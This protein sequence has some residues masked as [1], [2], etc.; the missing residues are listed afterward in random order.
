[1]SF[2]VSLS[3]FCALL[4]GTKH[5]H[6]HACRSRNLHLK[7]RIAEWGNFSEH[8]LGAVWMSRRAFITHKHLK[9]TFCILKLLLR[10][11]KG[12]FIGGGSHK[13]STSVIPVATQLRL[14]LLCFDKL[15]L[16]T[17]LQLFKKLVMQLRSLKLFWFEPE[18]IC[19]KVNFQVCLVLIKMDTLVNVTSVVVLETI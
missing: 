9:D 11:W 19:A 4:K 16:L 17:F 12:S 7:P 15:F 10:A 2:Q 1:M 18:V 5:I 6:T 14:F 13:P 8:V 3:C